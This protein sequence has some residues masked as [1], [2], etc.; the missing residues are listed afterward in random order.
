MLAAIIWLFETVLNV[1]TA[2]IKKV[3]Q[4]VFLFVA[5]CFSFTIG[6]VLLITYITR[7]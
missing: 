4:Y 6:I 1:A 2:T 3:V 7:N 5:L